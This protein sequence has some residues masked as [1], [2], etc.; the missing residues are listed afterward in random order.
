MR[1]ASANTASM[2]CSISR[3]VSSCLSSR[4][5]STMRRDS[6][7]PIPAIGSSSSSRRGEVASA[8]A[9]SSWRCSPWLSLATSMSARVAEPDARERRA[10]RFAQFRLAARIAPEAEGVAAM[11]L[12]RERDIVERREIEKE[13][14]DLERAR[15]PQLAAAPGWERGDVAAVEA[16]A[17][18][19]R[20]R[21]RRQA[22][23][24]ASSCRRRSVRSR[25][26]AR[27]ARLRA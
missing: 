25:R 17:S 23:R 12:H 26:A 11:R 18:C 3:M 10:R 6:S 14:R 9:I 19:V 8:I 5:I 4:R 16:D 20:A 22:R 13:R 15:E 1:S 7:G 21:A 27:R 24:S 2:S